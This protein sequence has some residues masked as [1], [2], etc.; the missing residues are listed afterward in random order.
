MRQSLDGDLMRGQYVAGAEATSAMFGVPSMPSVYAPQINRERYAPIQDNG[1]SLVTEQPVSTFSIDVDTGS[2]ANV[3]RLLNSGRLPPMDAVR[4]EEM[5]NYFDYEYATTSDDDRPFSVTTEVGPSPWNPHTRLFHIGVRGVDVGAEGLPPANLVFLVD[6]SGSMHSPDKLGLLKSALALLVQQLEAHD[7]ISLVVYAG[8]SAVVLDPT[9]GN[10]KARIRNAIESLAAGGSTDGGAGIELAYRMAR[11]AY[12]EGGINRI[13]LA[14]DGDFNVGTVDFEQ[15]IDLVER[16]RKSGVSLTTLGFGGGNYNDHLMERLADAGNG[17]YAYID[18]LQEARKVLVE[19]RHATLNT[20][21]ADVKIQVEFNP[22]TVA[23]YRL[24]GYENRLLDRED[25]NNDKVDA[26]EI[27]AGH[28]VTALYELT[29][30]DATQHR[31]DSLRYGESHGATA[32]SGDVDELAFLKLRYKVPGAS[33]STLLSTVIPLESIHDELSRTSDRYRFSAAVAGFAQLLRGGENLAA[34]H[35]DDV[36]NLARESR[37]TDTFGYR[38]EF[39]SLVAL[40]AT[41]EGEDPQVSN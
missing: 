13:L 6:V 19:E 27:G 2:Y 20:I 17:N 12:I 8:A 11:D 9:P 21:A 33:E 3:R 29:L 38:G 32:I 24:I 10:H 15:L 14:T 7:R 18:T 31:I 1:W 39:L 28:T 5:I 30:A 34:F 35:Y 22:A 25:F 41:L 23:E 4:V 16:E 26:G 37:G 40:A 36:M